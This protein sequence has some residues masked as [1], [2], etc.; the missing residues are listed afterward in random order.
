MLRFLIAAILTGCFLLPQP[1]W[2]QEGDKLLKVVVLSRH[3]V[4]SPTQDA[5]FLSMWSQRT[6]PAWPVARG[7]L[8]PRGAR[9][10]TAMWS[11]LL[12]R[13]TRLGVL[14]ENLCAAP[15]TI[16]VRADVDERT[17]AT[18]RAILA[19]L[20]PACSLGFAVL[21]NAGVDPLFH[22]MK[23]GLYRFNP[24]SAATDV[25]RMTEGGLNALEDRFASQIALIGD[26]LGTPA[27]RLCARYAMVPNC[28]LTDLPNAISL[29][30]EGTD[31]RIMGSLD[32]ASDVAEIFLLEYAQW[33]GEAA[34]WGNVNAKNLEQILPVHASVFDVVNRAPIV[35]WAKGSGLLSEMAAALLNRHY[36][37]ACNRAKL[38]IFVGHDTNIANI[39]ALLN[40][41]WQ[42][43]GYPPNG[44]P[45]AGALFLELWEK[46][47]KREV[48]ARFYAQTPKT[49]HAKFQ[50]DKGE[51]AEFAPVGS[52]VSA[53]PVVGEAR[54]DPEDFM[55][56]VARATEGAPMPPLAKPVFDYGAVEPAK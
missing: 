6:W 46:N 17:K 14:P 49:L 55:L 12:P 48:T 8:T 44:I 39:G 50:A 10:V 28:Q 52:E 7:D 32:I 51:M 23:A 16:Y 53:P 4:R 33:P 19:G 21:A 37:E 3:G 31:I 5:K 29:S 47:G 56:K 54:F 9:L 34:G 24:V 25:I 35:A 42:A 30:P 15:E 43:Q 18:A 13:F 20:A 26:I 45:P 11:Q 2:A 36:D 38:V 1:A 22:P 41:N 27:P 40:L